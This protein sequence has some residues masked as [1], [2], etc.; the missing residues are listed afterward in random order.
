SDGAVMP[1]LPD[2]LAVIEESDEEHPFRLV[3]APARGFLNTSF[4]ET[5]TSRKREKRPAVLIHPKAAE[6]LGIAEGDRVRLGN[7]RGDVLVHAKPF[8]GLQQGVVVVEGIWPNKAFEGGIGINALTGA[9][10]GAPNGG[11][12]FHDTAI[13]IRPAP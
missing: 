8:D 6:G 10:A 5:P 4:T 13:W 2:H 11:A 3:T 7:R 12:A 1:R 9:D